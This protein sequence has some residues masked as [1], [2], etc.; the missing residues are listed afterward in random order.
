MTASQMNTSEKMNATMVCQVY[1]VR[2]SQAYISPKCGATSGGK[3]RMFLCSF[4][5][6]GVF[7]IE[8]HGV[9]VKGQLVLL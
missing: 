7:Q 4:N 3:P 8:T 1:T 6:A 9:G 5:V 2:I